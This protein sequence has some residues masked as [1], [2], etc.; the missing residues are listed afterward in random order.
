MEEKM[1][2][3][4]EHSC[5]ITP[6]LSQVEKPKKVAQVHL[7]V[8]GSTN[9]CVLKTQCKIQLQGED[10]HAPFVFRVCVCAHSLG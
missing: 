7:E 4:L 5:L 2:W 3:R 1:S 6:R 10:K 9:H 8:S